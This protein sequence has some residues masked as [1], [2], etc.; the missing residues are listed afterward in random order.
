K[1]SSKGSTSVAS[2]YQTLS[3]VSKLSFRGSARQCTNS[4]GD[5]VAPCILKG[6][7]TPYLLQRRATSYLLRGLAT[8]YLLRRLA[9]PYLL[10][11]LATPYLLRGLATPY[12][13]R[14]HYSLVIS[15]GLEV[16]FIASAIPMERS[17]MEWFCLRNIR[18]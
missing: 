18:S 7:A 16:A 3:Y 13:L 6:L 2:M 8:P 17:N 11:G 9:T 1:L 14:R 5:N 12:L 15:F 4:D 10:R